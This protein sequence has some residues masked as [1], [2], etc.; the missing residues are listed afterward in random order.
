MGFDSYA[1]KRAEKR[2]RPHQIAR[3]RKRQ[4]R[5]QRSWSR[6]FSQERRWQGRHLC[7]KPQRQDGTHLEKR[8]NA[9][10]PDAPLRS[11][12]VS[13]IAQWA[14]KC[15]KELK[16]AQGQL[17][18]DGVPYVSILARFRGDDLYKSNK[19]TWGLSQDFRDIAALVWNHLGED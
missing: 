16:R 1:R 11:T 14:Q 3:Q 7:K 9:D 15:E 8:A 6:P 19:M 10:R 18:A 5:W 12:S 13:T 17:D 4:R 2:T